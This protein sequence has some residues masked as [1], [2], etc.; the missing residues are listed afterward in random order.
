MNFL[1][2]TFRYLTIIFVFIFVSQFICV[3]GK[4][5]FEEELGNLERFLDQIG[6]IKIE[7]FEKLKEKL[8]EGKYINF[9]ILNGLKS[10][11]EVVDFKIYFIN[12]VCF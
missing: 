10:V 4:R 2:K 9:E 11:D 5:N 6:E 3:L 1:Q 12:F 8:P 7:N